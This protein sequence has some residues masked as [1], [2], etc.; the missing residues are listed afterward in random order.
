MP[1]RRRRHALPNRV[2][3]LRLVFGCGIRLP[4]LAMV[5]PNAV[6]LL[7]LTSVPA[8]ATMR[9]AVSRADAF[10][11]HD[12][13]TDVWIIGNESIAASFGFTANHELTLMQLA[14]GSSG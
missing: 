11:S 6:V 7:G 4:S 12:D 3:L 9:L 5:V 14:H 2:T 8:A 10:V 13:Q 1:T